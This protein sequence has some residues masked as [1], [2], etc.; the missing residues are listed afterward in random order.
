MR[1][2][3]VFIADEVN[4][5]GFCETLSY[6][7]SKYNNLYLKCLAIQLPAQLGELLEVF[8][9]LS[10]CDDFIFLG[11]HFK[12]PVQYPYTE[13]L[14][15]AKGQRNPNHIETPQDIVTIVYDVWQWES[16]TIP[17]LCKGDTDIFGYLRI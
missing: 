3:I 14:K 5:K 15:L 16:H 17:Y 9:K 2:G 8:P 11:K 7:L 10:D 1:L 6:V 4:T 12:T 13:L